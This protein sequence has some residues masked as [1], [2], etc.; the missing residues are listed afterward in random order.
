MS[1]HALKRKLL[2]TSAKTVDIFLAPIWGFFY[3]LDKPK[4][5]IRLSIL[6]LTVVINMFFVIKRNKNP[7]TALMEKFLLSRKGMYGPFTTNQH[8]KKHIEQFI[9]VMGVS[10]FEDITDDSIKTYIESV[11]KSQPS[12]IEPLHAATAI[13][14][15]RQFYEKKEKRDQQHKRVGRPPKEERNMRLVT[16]RKGDPTYW[17]IKALAEEFKI[18]KRAVW[19]ILDRYKD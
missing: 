17:T 4:I 2:T 7:L 3:S 11:R 18:T 8:H 14:L 19:E 15:F 5:M 10:H 1:C 16:L 12:S 9:K 6:R 13:N